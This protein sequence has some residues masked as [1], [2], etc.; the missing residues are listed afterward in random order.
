MKIKTPHEGDSKVYK[1][2]PYLN[3]NKELF[4]L[5]NKGKTKVYVAAH[6]N[7]KQMMIKNK[8]VTTAEGKMKIVDTSWSKAM[9]SSIIEV[10]NT[11][12]SI[13]GE[14]EL[15]VHNASN[16]KKKGATLEIRKL[17]DSEY[18]H[19]ELLRNIITSLLDKF[20]KNE[21]LKT[22]NSRFKTEKESFKCIICQWETRSEP[23][24]K[25]HM[26]KLHSTGKPFVCDKCGQTSES[27]SKLQTHVRL[28]HEKETRKRF[29]PSFKCEECESTFTK[30]ERLAEHIV[31]QH[32]E[33]TEAV[34]VRNDSL[35]SPP[36]K[37]LE[38]VIESNEEEEMLELDSMEIVVE[39]ELNTKILQE[40]RINELE[41]LVEKMIDEK[42]Q[43]KECIAELANDLADMLEEKKKDEQ[44]ILALEKSLEGLEKSEHKEGNKHVVPVH[45]AHISKLKGFKLR[46]KTIGDGACFTNAIAVHVSK[47]ENESKNIKRRLNHHIA[48]NY[49][50]FY[51]FIL[52]LPYKETVGVGKGSKDVE[53]KTKEE[54]LEFLRSDESLNVYSNAHDVLAAA[55]LFKTRIHTFTYTGK[56][57][58]W[59]EVAP[60]DE[61]SSCA[62]FKEEWIPDIFLY[63]SMDNHFDLLVKDGDFFP[64]ESQ[65]SSVENGSCKPEQSRAGFTP[66]E[67]LNVEEL[68][69]ED[70][71]EDKSETKVELE[72]EFTLVRGKNSGH[73]RADPQSYAEK[74]KSTTKTFKCFKCDKE[75]ES[76]GLLDSH[77]KQL[78][79]RQNF[80][81]DVCQS[82]FKKR[83]DLEMHRIE[84][85]ETQESDEW[86]CNDC[87]FQ[88]TD[89]LELM[90]HLKIKSHQ[91]SPNIKDKRKIFQDYRRCYTCDLEV[92]GYFNL[93][94][95]R[96]EE[97]PSKRKC[98]NFPGGNCTWGKNCW[99][100]HSEE[101]MDVDESFKE[102]KTKYNCYNCHIEFETKD[103]FKKHKKREHWT[104]VETCTKFLASKCD[105]SEDNC[106]YL[107][108]NAKPYKYSSHQSPEKSLG[109]RKAPTNQPP[110]QVQI[111]LETIKS[112]DLRVQNIEKKEVELT[113]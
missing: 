80:S 56:E 94:N 6:E 62:E 52:P 108:E 71:S 10:V 92:D 86:N 76:Q 60:H 46:Y 22:S 35:A 85:H 67:V 26:K 112:L 64:M 36:R 100:V 43:D 105:R 97:H 4:G 83:L 31:S 104:N 53:L 7:I 50:N 17:S 61:M 101:L 33:N 39:R 38:T 72:E 24:L 68:L 63:H 91:P 66:Q 49:E 21:D 15:K 5:T 107:H 41:F 98:R 74:V 42:K 109:F 88:A 59:S 110:D 55:N 9:V 12:N 103:D 23:A 77:V 1:E 82:E 32:G 37:K 51:K 70:L 102:E 13:Y 89:P 90:K 14:V 69:V 27:K 47:D 11:D 28:N 96:K 73:R 95:H 2:K 99:Y 106:W 87:A 18:C 111:I 81:C 30:K 84:Q 58:I 113:N 65:L 57:G 54:L 93:M 48:D 45:D 78:H 29:T 8:Q 25:G 75:L 3:S 40:K 44:R 16:D 34:I 19:V 20:M 79:G